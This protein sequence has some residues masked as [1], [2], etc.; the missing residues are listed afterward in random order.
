VVLFE[1]LAPDQETN[2][3]V[4]IDCHGVHDMKQVDDPESAVMKENLLGTCQKCHPDATADFPTSWLGHYPPDADHAP[5][6]FF[7][8]LFYLIFIPAVLGI[9]V[10]FVA[11]DVRKR[12]LGRS[13]EAQHG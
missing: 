1:K 10:V 2:K 5:L 11:T 4:C 3:P 12:F 8:R 6:V 9:M 7:V 13:K